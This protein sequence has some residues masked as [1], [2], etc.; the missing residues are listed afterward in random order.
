[1]D[2][3]YAEGQERRGP[4]SEADLN[5]KIA[6]GQIT[7]ET[8]VWNQT[9]AQWQPAGTTALFAAAIPPASPA[10]PSPA[11]GEETHVCI[12]TNKT[13]PV[14]QMIQTEHGW[15]SA[16]GRDT[17]YQA[18]RERVPLPTAANAPNARADGKRVVVPASNARLPRRCVK[19]NQPVPDEEFK[20]RTLYWCTPWVF[21]AVLLNLLIALIL[22]LVFRKK[23]R[24]E[25]PLSDAGR[26]VVNKHR[27]IA[28]GIAV[29]SIALIVAGVA[30]EAY[31]LIPLGVVGFLVA[32]VYSSFKGSLIRVTKLKDGYAWLAGAS[33]EYVASLPPYTG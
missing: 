27:W 25:V 7:R 12:I 29:V 8:L 15:V 2:W 33:P 28:I 21:I 4:I 30:T 26:K 5:A 14:S 9:F 3:Y 20:M 23:V 1:M 31:A 6:A 13:F 17:Y 32:I 24:L 19:T 10:T 22:Y 16:E 11:S 18:L